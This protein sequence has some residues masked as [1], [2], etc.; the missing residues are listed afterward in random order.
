VIFSLFLTPQS[1]V[2]TVN[3]DA[4]S[5]V[6]VLPFETVFPSTLCVPMLRMFLGLPWSDTP[7][8]LPRRAD[9]IVFFLS[10]ALAAPTDSFLFL[11]FLPSLPFLHSHLARSLPSSSAFWLPL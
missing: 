3:T 7:P 9:R 11:L 4:Q 10:Q 5:L 8:L 1:L 6:L 2:L